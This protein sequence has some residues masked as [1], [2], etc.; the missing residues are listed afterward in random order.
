VDGSTQVPLRYG[1]EI[2]PANIPANCTGFAQFEGESRTSKTPCWSG[3]YSNLVSGSVIADAG[4]F[5]RSFASSYSSSNSFTIYPG[6]SARVRMYEQLR[7]IVK[8]PSITRRKSRQMSSALARSASSND[9]DLPRPFRVGLVERRE[10]FPQRGGMPTQNRNESGP[11]PRVVMRGHQVI[12]RER[13]CCRRSILQAAG[14]P[15][16]NS[17]ATFLTSIATARL[18]LSCSARAIEVFMR[19]RSW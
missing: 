15:M 10:D 6:S 17:R 7:G 16:P 18:S 14:Q 3:G 19:A 2:T 1:R 4:S 5:R 9:I 8:D 12:D 11:Q 13:R